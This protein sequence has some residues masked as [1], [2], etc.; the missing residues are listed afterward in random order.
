MTPSEPSD[1][2]LQPFQDRSKAPEA[3]RIVEEAQEAPYPGAPEEEGVAESTPRRRKR[4]TARL[5]WDSKPKKAPNPKNLGFQIA[6]VV[7]P[8]PATQVGPRLPFDPGTQEVDT[9]ACNRLIWGDNLLVMQALLAQGYEGKINLIYID[10]PF[11]S[12]A[13]YSHSVQLTPDEAGKG[14]GELN[15][16]MSVLE[17][18]AYRDTWED[19]TDSYLDM[20]YPRLQLMHRLLA[21]D[22]S[23]YVHCDWR[24]SGL[25]RLILDEVF[26]KSCFLNE[27]IW[28]YDGPQAPSP[29]KFASK[30]DTIFRYSKSPEHLV[31]G[32]MYFKVTDPFRAGQYQQDDEGRWF[33]TIPKGDYTE[34][35]IQHLDLEGRIFWTSTGTPRIKKFV[36]LS[37]DGQFVIKT[38]KIPDVW[39][40]TS[41]GLAAGSSENLSYPTQKP[42]ALLE[43]ILK[44][45]T[46]PNDLVAD[47]FCGSGTTA[48]VAE[49]LGRRWITSDLGKASIQVARNRFV[50]MGEPGS[51]GLA[52]QRPDGATRCAPFVVENLGNYQRQLLYLH[53]TRLKQVGTLILTLYGA[54]PHP[55]ERALGVQGFNDPE[56]GRF[57]RRLVLVGDPDRPL[58]AKR[59]AEAAR[60]LKSLDGGGYSRLVAL[61]WDFELNFD[62][63]LD[64]HL[65]PDW[66]K[67]VEVRQIPTEVIEY[68]KK[69]PADAGPDDPAVERLRA[70]VAF[71]EKPFLAPPELKLLGWTGE[72]EPR[73]RVSLKLT[74]Y[75]LRG[76]PM[77][78]QGKKLNE[79]EARDLIQKA[80]GPA[81]LNLID[82]W[83]VDD[84]LGGEDGK[85]PFTS[86]WQALRGLGKRVKPVT[87][88]TEL[89]YT[90]RP[91]RRAALRLVDLFGNDALWTGL[92][93]DAED[94]RRAGF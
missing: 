4:N 2:T 72:A 46:T 21:E 83:S 53:D 93:P 22:G 10:P 37:S 62:R 42:E 66:R 12:K 64:K 25:I 35:S 30:H 88:E 1:F 49:K 65:G 16:E 31:T 74:R 3:P 48:A 45:S 6:E 71:F 86:T 40:I 54:Q 91:G 29:T 51:G 80:G 32:V 69:I 92:L 23:I 47:F 81:G 33:Y 11:D 59:V 67:V 38:K 7:V 50:K 24:V 79:A 56:T 76:L 70:Q 60:S 43:R 13:D 14:G 75:L 17:R 39:E 19:G 26:G 63:A 36:D 8:N 87:S 82:F 68:L 5:V 89:I 9:Q 85:R 90:P 15:A 61:G 78:L 44:A 73:L 58:S 34:K 55:T 20:L 77:G 52:F 84:D 94:A 18:L 28:Q 27:I 57:Q 41:L